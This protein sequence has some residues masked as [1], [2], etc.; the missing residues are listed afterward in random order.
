MQMNF[1]RI[2]KTARSI[3]LI[4]QISVLAAC[5]S[6]KEEAFDYSSYE[7]Q[8]SF[9]SEHF[10][11][12]ARQCSVNENVTSESGSMRFRACS[13]VKTSTVHGIQLFSSSGSV[14]K[15]CVFPTVVSNGVTSPIV[16]NP[17]A[18]AESRFLKICGTIAYTGSTAQIGHLDF[19]GLLLMDAASVS[20]F[21]QCLTQS[22]F[23]SCARNLSIDF[24]EGLL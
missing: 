5:A 6:A 17:S 11:Q 10:E 8:A 4:A 7:Q 23:R 1:A 9:S 2:L 15:M 22:D 3:L 16:T 18:P 24:A 19:N 14:Q 20:A 21:S 13:T 12:L